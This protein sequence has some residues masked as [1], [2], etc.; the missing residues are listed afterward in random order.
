M[1]D[2]YSE[3]YVWCQTD[4]RDYWCT[5]QRRRNRK[6]STLDALWGESNT[7]TGSPQGILTALLG[8]RTLG[9]HL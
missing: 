8:D 4:P 2:I 1:Q 7:F 9:A 6:V 3:M 5:G